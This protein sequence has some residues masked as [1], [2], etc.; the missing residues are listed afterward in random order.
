MASVAWESLYEASERLALRLTCRPAKDGHH[1][2]LGFMP[3]EVNGKP[4][5][6]PVCQLNAAMDAVAEEEQVDPEDRL[7]AVV[8]LAI[9][10]MKSEV[11]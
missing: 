8:D 7:G 1:T 3:A 9:D 4:N 6:C 5:K 11:A 10:E 2:A